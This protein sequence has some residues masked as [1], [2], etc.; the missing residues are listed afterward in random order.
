MLHKRKIKYYPFIKTL[1]FIIVGFYFCD[2][3]LLAQNVQTK[4]THFKSLHSGVKIYGF[5]GNLYWHTFYVSAANYFKKR[6]QTELQVQ[7]R[8]IYLLGDH[9][10]FGY[11]VLATAFMEG[12]FKGTVFGG[13]GGGPVLRIYPLKYGRWQPYLQG[14]FIAGFDLAQSIPGSFQQYNG[15]RYRTGLRAG[16]NYRFTNAFGIFFE[17]GP[18]WEYGQ[19]LNLDSHSLQINIGIELFRF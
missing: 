8:N 2:N 9:V 11:K 10:G 13:V 7:F 15:V 18:E 17:I 5:T 14:G 3:P 6:S 16:L 19:D 12:F 4:N 1:T